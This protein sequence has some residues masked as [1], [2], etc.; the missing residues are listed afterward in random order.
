[1]P[2]RDLTEVELKKLVSERGLRKVGFHALE[3]FKQEDSKPSLHDLCIIELS[4]RIEGTAEI[5]IQQGRQIKW[6][7]EEMLKRKRE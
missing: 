3:V 6:L 4:A 2:D 7:K 1:M 5:L